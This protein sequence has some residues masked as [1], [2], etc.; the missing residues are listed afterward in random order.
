MEET[1]NK[2]RIFTGNVLRKVDLKHQEVD[3]RMILSCKFVGF[4]GGDVP[5]RDLLGCDAVWCYGRIPPF[6]RF[7]LP[8]SSG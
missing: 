6:Q 7:M 8:P 2:Y 3:R 4:H 1:G 5:S